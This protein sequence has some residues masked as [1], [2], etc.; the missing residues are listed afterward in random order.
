M[1]EGA[2]YGW[3]NVSDGIHY[4][5]DPFPDND[6]SDAYAR[7]AITWTPVIAPGSMIFYRHDLF[8]GMKGDA[9]IAGLSSNA[10][11]RV[12]IDGEKAREVARYP[13]DQRIRG[14]AQGPDG[15]LWVIEDGEGGRQ[16]KLTPG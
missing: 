4:E 9:L 2:N 6:T 11:V 13:M 16:L 1:R 10:I 15:A 5:G 3:P 14:V 12:A 8:P 7:P